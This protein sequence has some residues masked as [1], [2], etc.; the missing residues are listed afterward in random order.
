MIVSVRRDRRLRAL[1]GE[2]AG[3]SGRRGSEV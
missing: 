1:S 3:I 2:R